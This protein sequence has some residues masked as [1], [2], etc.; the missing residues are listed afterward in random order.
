M[1]DSRDLCRREQA[2]CLSWVECVSVQL[3]GENQDVSP[4]KKNKKKDG[5]AA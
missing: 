5:V 2:L 1:S 4:L 3:Q